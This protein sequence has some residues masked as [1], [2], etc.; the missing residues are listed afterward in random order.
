MWH[1]SK[2]H[3][4]K[5]TKPKHSTSTKH[6]DYKSFFLDASYQCGASD[7]ERQQDG[8]QGC[9]GS[10]CRGNL[11]GLVVD[12]SDDVQGSFIGLLARRLDLIRRELEAERPVVSELEG[13]GEGDPFQSGPVPGWARVGVY[14]NRI[15]ISPIFLYIHIKKN[16]FSTFV[17]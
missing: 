14:R 13:V 6:Q 5:K 8:P 1:L 3:S 2:V 11:K 7:T 12:V 9:G 4:K 16:I 10:G 15:Q 17:I